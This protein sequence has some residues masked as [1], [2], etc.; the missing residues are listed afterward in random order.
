[1]KVAVLAD[2]HGNLEALLAV[3]ADLRRR[4]AERV[5]CLG[6]SI[7]YGPDPEEVVRQLRRLG[8]VSVL[9]NHEMALTDRRA[10]K[11]MNFQAEENNIA[12]EGLLS[13]ESLAYCTSLPKYLSCDQAYF[14]HGYPPE[15]VFLYL[16]RQPDARIISLLTAATA[17]LFFL[18]HT[19]QLQL[20]W[21]EDGAIRRRAL[22]RERLAL[23]PGQK[24]IVNAGSVGQPRDGDHHAKYLLWDT[25]AATLEVLFVAY[26]FRTTIEKIKERGFPAAYAVRLG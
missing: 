1:M 16:N 11:W 8:A 25:Q 18:G 26:D 17:S 3:N 24:Y 4:G 6:D 14:V 9:G 5:I 19:H 10:R 2:I 15:S 20:V 12:T 13:P 23:A 22:G 7:G 21:L